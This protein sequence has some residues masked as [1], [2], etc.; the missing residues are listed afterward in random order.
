M[1]DFL[2]NSCLAAIA[3]AETGSKNDNSNSAEG[4]LALV[5]R[6]ASLLR[7]CAYQ[8]LTAAPACV[9]ME[10]VVTSVVGHVNA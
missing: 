8:L 4:H 1:V 6:Q 3:S 5:N 10:G 7:C 2:N 9:R